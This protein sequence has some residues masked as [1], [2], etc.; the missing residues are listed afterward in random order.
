MLTAYCRA[1]YYGPVRHGPSNK[2]S[3]VLR[4]VSLFLGRPLAIQDCHFTT[5]EPANV[6]DHDLTSLSN[7]PRPFDRPIKSTFLILHFRLARIIGQIQC[8]CFGLHPRE[9]ND[10][11][12][13]ENMLDLYSKML[14]P[15]F[16]LEAADTSLDGH[17][18][19]RWLRPQRQTLIS[20]FHL[21]RIS[22][23]RPYLLRSFGKRSD[24]QFMPSRE[25]CLLSSI[26]DINI[27]TT[28]TDTDPLDRFKW[29]TVSPQSTESSQADMHSGDI[30]L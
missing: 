4:S 14:P 9:Y 26:A 19:Y 15:H 2:P 7:L 22:L 10:V 16:R 8:R 21:A 17:E 5:H 20:K 11:L 1:V 3:D 30:R 23:H 27:R 29:M 18:G 25:A 28:L 6:T 13:C 12:D 24:P